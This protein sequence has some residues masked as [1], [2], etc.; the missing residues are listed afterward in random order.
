MEILSV[1]FHSFSPQGVTG[2]I[3]IST[4]HFSIHTWPEKGYTALDL[5]TCGEQDIWPAFKDILDKLKAKRVEVYEVNRG[6][7]VNQSPVRKKLNLT[8]DTVNVESG[9]LS[10]LFQLRD[11]QGNDWDMMQL[12]QI[13]IGKHDILYHGSSPFQDILLVKANEVRLYKALQNLEPMF[14]ISS[15]IMSF[16]NSAIVNSIDN[17]R[18]HEIYQEEINT[19]T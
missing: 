5:Y 8:S 18:L 15:D 19:L 11:D 12:K 3:G 13:T 7:E 17:L 14:K 2:V 9:N 16:Q 6:E 1:H 10:E 4:S